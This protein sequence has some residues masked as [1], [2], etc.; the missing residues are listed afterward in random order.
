MEPV[1]MVRVY[2]ARWN[3]AELHGWHSGRKYPHDLSNVFSEVGR[4]Q[5]VLGVRQ[6]VRDILMVGGL[7]EVGF[8]FKVVLFTPSAQNPDG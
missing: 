6:W 4:P 8:S 7:D 5:P 1:V 3:R 2:R